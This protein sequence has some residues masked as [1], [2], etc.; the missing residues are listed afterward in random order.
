V[1][2]L[3]ALTVTDLAR[4]FEHIEAEAQRWL[5]R[6]SVPRARCRLLRAVDMR[7]LGQNFEL[8]VPVPP[9]LWT[10]DLGALKHA[11]LTEHERVYGYATEDEAIQIVNIRL[12]ALGEPEPLDLPVLPRAAGPDAG[13]ARTT[14]RNVYFQ[15]VGGFVPTPI[16]RRERLRSGHHIAGPAVV[17]Q[18]DCTTVIL[19]GQRAVVDDRANLL[20]DTGDD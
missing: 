4:R 8:T 15:E 3:D 14:E 12:A 17:E 1:E 13:A 2:A 20:I 5:D 18:M 19:P 16:Y 10:G 7:Y 6:E 11:F 9:A